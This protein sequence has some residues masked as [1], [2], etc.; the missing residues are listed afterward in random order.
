MP[1][2]LSRLFSSTRLCSALKVFF[3]FDDFSA[4][5]VPSKEKTL[6]M[7]ATRSQELVCVSV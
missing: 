5:R 3:I 1:G 2:Y 7:R 6:L 4:Y